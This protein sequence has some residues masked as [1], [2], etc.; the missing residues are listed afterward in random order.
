MLSEVEH[1]KSFI[2]SGPAPKRAPSLAEKDDGNATNFDPALLAHW[3][4]NNECGA[5]WF[6]YL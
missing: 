1:E 4:Y 6:S 3:V 2:T 5:A